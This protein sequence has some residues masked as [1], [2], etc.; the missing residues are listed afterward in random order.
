MNSS[1]CGQGTRG[2]RRRRQGMHSSQLQGWGSAAACSLFSC[3]SSPAEKCLDET[4]PAAARSAGCG[5]A[6]VAC[7][8]QQWFCCPPASAHICLTQHQCP[9]TCSQSA[10]ARKQQFIG[11]TH[12]TRQLCRVEAAS[13]SK[14]AA[15]TLLQCAGYQ[16]QQVGCGATTH[17][18][19]VACFDLLAPP[20]LL[21]KVSQPIN[22]C[23]LRQRQQRGT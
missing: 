14:T 6:A 5:T 12:A 8:P 17:Q 15:H 1:G 20:L 2:K 11:V 16:C 18:H 4:L 9:G 3:A 13:C 19:R 10:P 22:L 7:A 21:V 23:G